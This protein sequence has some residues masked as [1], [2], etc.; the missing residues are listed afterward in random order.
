M[1]RRLG[2]LQPALVAQSPT[3]WLAFM[4]VQRKG[5]K[6][7]VGQTTDSG[8]HW[9]SPPDLLLNN[10]DSAVAALALGSSQLLMAHNSALR[11]RHELTLSTSVDAVNWSTAAALSRGPQGSEFSYP[12]LAWSDGQLWVTFTDNRERIAWQRFAPVP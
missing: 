9:R 11:G 7:G 8:V 5:G 12:A 2:M 6:V 1:T 10:P 4:R 3:D